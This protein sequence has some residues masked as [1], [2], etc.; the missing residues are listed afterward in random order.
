MHNT[1][2]GS[3]YRWD[4]KTTVEEVHR[5]D[6]RFLRKHGLLGRVGLSGNLQWSRGGRPTGSISYRVD[7]AA[8]VLRYRHR[9]SDG[10]FHDVEENVPLDRT[11]CNFGG[12]RLWFLCPRCSRRV[13]VLYAAGKRF[14]CRHCHDLSY[15]SQSEIYS[16]RMMRKARKI[17]RR[18]GASENL[19]DPILEKPK[20]MHWRT[21]DRL[22]EDERETNDAWR[23]AIEPRLKMLEESNLL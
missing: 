6:I 11:P 18:L 19:W 12:E 4:R 20:G 8:L 23:L 15:G 7:H 1:G 10:A 5:V 3:W 22:V 9:T 2:S 16:D 17:R 21:F 13:A 14:L